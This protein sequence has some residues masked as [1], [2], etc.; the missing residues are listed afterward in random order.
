MLVNAFSRVFL[1][2]SLVIFAATRGPFKSFS[3][4]LNS[5]T[6][7]L[8]PYPLALGPAQQS[9]ACVPLFITSYHIKPFPSILI[10][11]Y[12]P[13]YNQKRT[14]ALSHGRSPLIPSAPQRN[15]ARRR[16][17]PLRRTHPQRI[18]LHTRRASPYI[19]RSPFRRTHPF[20]SAEHTRTRSVPTLCGLSR[21]ASSQPREA[22][23]LGC[24]SPA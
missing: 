8:D 1:Y 3:N 23:H 20:G 12:L 5:K 2:F 14:A 17:V 22:R 24:R 7:S 6:P 16:P 10:F 18:A 9:C 11:I 13:T 4:S 19:S 15:P 21:H